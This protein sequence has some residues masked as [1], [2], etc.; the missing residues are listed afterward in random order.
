[1]NKPDLKQIKQ[2]M[3]EGKIVSKSTWADVI[4]YAVKV[5]AQRYNLLNFI[6]HAPVDSGICCCGEDMK[7]HVS[8]DHPPTDMYW[9]SV[10]CFQREARAID[11]LPV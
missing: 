6:K 9:H 2:D 8:D 3:E 10:E 1:M 7:S 11:G 5:D 4:A